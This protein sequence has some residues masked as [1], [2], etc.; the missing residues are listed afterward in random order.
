VSE[1]PRQ[2]E[3][4]LVTGP[5]LTVLSYTQ[6]DTYQRC[7]QMYQYRF[8]FR[9]P[10]R[11]RPQMQFGRIL[12][13]ALRDALGAIDSDHPLTWQM[14]DAAYISAWAK[15]RFCAP[16]QVQSLQ[17]LG[18]DYL[19]RAYDS[20]HLRRPLLI[21]QPFSLR[22]DGLRLTGRID[23]VDRHHDGTYEVIDYKTGTQ[24]RPAELQRDLQL[25]VYALAA[26]EVFR[27]Q[28]L[29]LS[30]LY[31]ET[32]ERVTVDKPAARLEEDRETIMRVADG[33]RSELFPA[34]PERYKCAGCDFKEL[35]PSSVA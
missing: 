15:G 16:E 7:P 22:I 19:R 6:V 28:P 1:Q 29:T 8:V 13:E 18:R 33:I 12:H 2:V 31:L 14:V 30:Y 26:R 20:G 9:L 11:P 5:P 4:P 32:A 34:K 21:E 10:T 35:C 23:R 27:F 25:G 24:R 3:L 17:E